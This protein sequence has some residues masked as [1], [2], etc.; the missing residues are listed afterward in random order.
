ME[1]VL[2]PALALL[3][4]TY[5]PLAKPRIILGNV[6]TAAG[7]FF[8]A[9]RGQLDFLLLSAMLTGIALV[10]GSACVFNNYIDR[11]HD[12]KMHRTKNR[13]LAKGDVHIG[14]TLLHAGVLVV[15]G[16][17]ILGL[18]AN[19]LTAGIAVFGFLVYVLAYSF[20]KYK[21]VHATLIGS[22]AGATPP[23]IGYV[24]VTGQTDLAAFIIFAIITFWQMPHFFAIAIYRI[25]DYTKAA[26]PLLPIK[27]GLQRTKIQMVI[28]CLVYLL[29]VAALSFFGFVGLGFL[30]LNTLFGLRWLWLCMQGFRCDNDVQWARGVFLF[31]LVVVTVLCL[32]IP[33]ST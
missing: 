14:R 19:L 11:E 7:G 29:S 33:F 18:Y 15:L 20:L 1:K 30:V 8:L 31:S 22:I 10:I 24:A 13:A 25:K 28:Y 21:T 2:R 16:V 26:V 9:A 5:C 6:I 32:S 12:K 27:K 23:V 4:K 17:A 3:I